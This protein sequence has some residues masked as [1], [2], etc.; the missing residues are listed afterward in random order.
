MTFRHSLLVCDLVVLFAWFG[1]VF[2]IFMLT[3]RCHTSGWYYH[4]VP[5]PHADHAEPVGLVLDHKQSTEM[6]MS[7]VRGL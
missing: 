2:C 6:F 1:S 5:F 3:K 7:P 4:L